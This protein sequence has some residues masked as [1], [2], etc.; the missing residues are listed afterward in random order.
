MVESGQKSYVI[1]IKVE[2][3]DG[4]FFTLN[5]EDLP[6]LCLLGKDPIRL[7]KQ[8]PELVK[9]LFKLNFEADVLVIPVSKAV[10]PKCPTEDLVQVK[11]WTAIE[12]A[13]A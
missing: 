10:L 12:R 4:G 8:V 11:T 2:L 13:I 5:T 7:I 9:K 6:G 3:R 1:N